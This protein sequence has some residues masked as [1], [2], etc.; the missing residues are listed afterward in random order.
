[1]AIEHGKSHQSSG[2]HDCEAFK[3]RLIEL[4]SG[5]EAADREYKLING[6]FWSMVR[7]EFTTPA[8]GEISIRDSGRVVVED[9]PNKI[10]QPDFLIAFRVGGEDIL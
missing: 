4:Q 3:T 2:D 5:L 8:T 6:I 9:R 10:N 7:L 1:M